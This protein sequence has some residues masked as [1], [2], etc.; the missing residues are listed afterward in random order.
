MDCHL[1]SSANSWQVEIAHAYEKNGAACLSILTDEKH[2]LVW[3]LLHV[4]PLLMKFF[5]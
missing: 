5:F 2:F 1:T 3:I 4:L